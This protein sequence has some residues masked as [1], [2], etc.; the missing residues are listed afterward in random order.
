[1]NNGVTCQVGIDGR[2]PK[3]WILLDNQSTVD[4][5]YNPELL[6]NIRTGTGSMTAHCNA[7]VTTTNLIGKLS[8]YGTGW[9]HPDGIANI[10]SLARVKEQGYRVTYDSKGENRFLI[11]KSDGSVRTFKESPHGLYYLDVG[12]YADSKTTSDEDI[13]DNEAGSPEAILINTVAANRANCTNRAYERAV[14]ARKIQKMIGRPS[15][16]E[17][18]QIVEKRLPPNCPVTRADIVAAEKIF[19][20]D[21]GILTGKTVRRG[22]EHF[23]IAKV[24]IPAEMMSAYRDV[25]IGDDV[26]YINKL[27][28]FVT[29]YRNLKFSTAELTLG[30][31]QTTMIDHVKRIQRIYHKRGFCVSTFLMDGQFDVIRGNL[32][33]VGITFNTVARGEHV[34][35]IERHI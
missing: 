23:E 25:N 32:A 10:L 18:I 4:I 12:E 29:M 2:V 5:L 14:S 11:H 20:P 3:S 27:P 28:F 17:C 34:P 13:S 15:T 7:G 19:G 1:M 30:Q 22:T 35:E 8:G 6:T 24:T 26:I 16:A 21:V 33:D 31:K 9:Y